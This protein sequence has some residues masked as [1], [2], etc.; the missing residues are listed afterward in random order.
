MKKAH[1]LFLTKG[2]K[3]KKERKLTCPIC[4]LNKSEIKNE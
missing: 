1:R 2:K 4:Y 3:K